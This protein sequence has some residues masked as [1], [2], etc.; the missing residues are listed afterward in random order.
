VQNYSLY[1]SLSLS[2]NMVHSRWKKKT[3]KVVISHSKIMA[4]KWLNRN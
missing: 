2:K 1:L 3:E 4:C